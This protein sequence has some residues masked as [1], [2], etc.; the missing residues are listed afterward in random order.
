MFVANPVEAIKAMRANAQ[1]VQIVRH[2]ETDRFELKF[3]SGLKD[4][5]DLVEAIMALGV[6]RYLIRMDNTI[7]DLNA[8]VRQLQAD[9]DP[10]D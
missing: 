8:L 10:K 2:P 7:A 6:R 9:V 1:N 3:G 5:K 4:D